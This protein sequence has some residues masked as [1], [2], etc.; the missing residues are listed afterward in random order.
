ME[1]YFELQSRCKRYEKIIDQLSEEIERLKSLNHNL[2][3][4]ITTIN[5]TKR[6]TSQILEIVTA[7]QNTTHQLKSVQLQIA[8][9]GFTLKPLSSLT[10][11][12]DVKNVHSVWAM[13]ELSDKRIITGGDDGSIAVCSLYLNTRTWCLD[14]KKHQAHD[15]RINAFCELTF[16]RVVSC[17]K[18]KSIKI[19][20]V[21]DKDLS[22]IKTISTHVGTVRK[23]ITLTNNRFA[24]CSWDK[25]IK[26]FNCDNT[27]DEVETI[28]EGCPVA[29]LLQLKSKEEIV[30]NGANTTISFWNISTYKRD[31]VVKG[32]RTGSCNG[33]LEISKYRLLAVASV[34]DACIFMV[35]TN[36]Y[37]VVANIK[38]KQYITKDDNVCSLCLLNNYS[39]IYTHSDSVCQIALEGY[40]VVFKT[41][42]KDAFRGS[43]VLSRLFGKYVI[44]NNK[45]KGITV[46]ECTESESNTKEEGVPCY[47]EERSIEMMRILN[48]INED[49]QLIKAQTTKIVSPSFS[50][51][52]L[53]VCVRSDGMHNIW[54]VVEFT[55]KRIITGGSDGSIVVSSVDVENKVWNCDIKYPKAHNGGITSFCICDENVLISSSIDTTLKVWKVSQTEITL[56]HSLT[57]HE[58]EV[59]KVITLTNNRLASG[60]LDRSIR[61]WNK[62]E[63]F[64]EIQTLSEGDGVSSLLQLRH[65]EVLMCNGPDTSLSLWETVNYTKEHTI[66]GAWTGCINSLIQLPNDYIAVGDYSSIYIVNPVLYVVEKEIKDQ[67]F[68]IK[69]NYSFSLY[70]L[71]EH[72]FI[73]AHSGSFCQISVYDYDIVYKRKFN[74]E[75]QGAGL[76]T[77]DEGKYIIAKN[78]NQG[79]TVFDVVKA[80]F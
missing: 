26:I 52:N 1:N 68:I 29:S 74:S 56:T 51:W 54:A 34:F 2:P 66:K 49:L 62:D 63:S 5:D 69:D 45:H 21:S 12:I 23:V 30:C 59:R 37:T 39:F 64:T 72:S 71:D 28:H 33:M 65:K 17:S 50:I 57:N 16:N 60:S 9:E 75:F 32:V 42:I 11:V 14:I 55:D 77:R 8:R 48:P 78:S 31:H 27:Y 40:D 19:W 7:V 20:K 43:T 13:L 25:T 46:F 73:Y 4:L 44:S 58:G 67:E 38:E 53:N 22:I 76:F 70:V 10:P 41:Q 35:D 3:E 18:D 36:T 24:S 80:Q 6:D 79:V 15:E 61:I 47:K